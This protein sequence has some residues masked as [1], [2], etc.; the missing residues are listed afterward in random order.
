MT[1]MLTIHVHVCTELYK[2]GIIGVIDV[3]LDKLE[4]KNEKK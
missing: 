2:I 4:A 1:S 3:N